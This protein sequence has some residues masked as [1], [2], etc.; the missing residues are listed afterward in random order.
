V[1]ELWT[2]VLNQMARDE[3]IDSVQTALT[4]VLEAWFAAILNMKQ[5][6]EDFWLSAIGKN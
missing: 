3:S 4:C 5:R 2:V 6:T 1:P